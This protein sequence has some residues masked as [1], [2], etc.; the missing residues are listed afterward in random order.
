[1]ENNYS[2]KVSSDESKK[3]IFRE[4]KSVY[5]EISAAFGKSDIGQVLSF[6]TD[7]EEMVKISNGIVSRGKKELSEYFNKRIDQLKDLS[8]IIDNIQL[9]IIDEN[10]V[11]TFANEFINYNGEKH[12][13]IVSNIFIKTQNGWKILLDHTTYLE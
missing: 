3:E 11:W 6:F 8:I 10:H 7:N 5:N 13:A 12:K 1:M 4:I 2:S 9:H